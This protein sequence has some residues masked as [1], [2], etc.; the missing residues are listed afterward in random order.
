[1]KC[2]EITAEV[3]PIHSK[4]SVVFHKEDYAKRCV[5][6]SLRLTEFISG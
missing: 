2:V 1:M 6:I 4:L 3:V 5:P